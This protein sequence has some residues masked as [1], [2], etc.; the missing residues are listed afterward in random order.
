MT[1]QVTCS[2]CYRTYGVKN[3]YAGRRIKCPD[4]ASPVQIPVRSEGATT[5][6]HE[7][8]GDEFNIP[9]QAPP[10]RPKARQQKPVPTSSGSSFP[11]VGL[12]IGGGVVA[13]LVCAGIIG[14]VFI[15][16]NND[17]GGPVAGGGKDHE[18]DQV[19]DANPGLQSRVENGSLGFSDETLETGEYCERFPLSTNEGDLFVIDMFSDEFD[20]Y[21]IVTDDD[22]PFQVEND[23]HAGDT[24]RSQVMFLA[25]KSGAYS[26]IATSFEEG[27]TGSY[28]VEIRDVTPDPG[29]VTGTREE[30]GELAEN[31]STL[32]SG[33]Y[34]DVHKLSAE[35]GDVFIIDLYSDEF[36]PYLFVTCQDLGEYQIDNDDFQGAFDHSRITMMAP[37][38]GTY[39]LTITTFEEGGIGC[40]PPGNLGVLK[41][42]A[43]M[44]SGSGGD[45]SQKKVPG[46]DCSLS[47]ACAALDIAVVPHAAPQGI[48][49]LPYPVA[50][51]FRFRDIRV[52]QRV[53]FM[54]VEHA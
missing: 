1:I 18:I 14:A 10:P 37:V 21:L 20:P 19:F 7:F 47:A 2:S 50:T 52:F 29:D 3:E 41:R 16:L 54:V 44:C 43:C 13:L 23:D 5:D 36:D 8:G 45:V 49:G 42:I 22:G 9:T 15:A 30:S 33:E 48:T 39:D 26:V 35:A 40:L 27:E 6:E 12:I 51:L 4:C 34:R 53:R 25:P 17:D 46:A 38:A 11:I 31:D 28:R 24:Q 32:E